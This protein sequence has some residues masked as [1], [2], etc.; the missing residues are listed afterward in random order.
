MF[1]CWMFGVW[2]LF[3]VV[4]CAL[5]VFGG[6]CLFGVVF[7]WMIG[8]RCVLFLVC[9]VLLEVCCL[10]V[11]SNR[12]LLVGWCLLAGVDGVALCVVCCL[13]FGVCRFCLFS[14]HGSLCVVSFGLAFGVCCRLGVVCM[15][16]LGV[17]CWLF[18]SCCALFV[19]CWLV[20]CFCLLLLVGVCWLVFVGWC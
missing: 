19:D 13:M 20:V 7:W 12:V 6:C 18:V 14:G 16:W 8:V 5:C 1:V 2:R 9:G 3:C 17:Y 11:V 10:F 15:D 4:C